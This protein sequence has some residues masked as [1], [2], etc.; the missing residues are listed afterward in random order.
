MAAVE[1]DPTLAER[2]VEQALADCAA[3]K[4]GGSVP[5]ARQALREGRCEVCGALG[6]SLA[7]Q[8]SEFVGRMDPTVKALYRA[9]GEP[10]ARLL[11]ANGGSR[12]GLNLVAWVERKSAALH[13][14]AGALEAGLAERRRQLGCRN[15][16]PACFT[17]DL[18]MVD[19]DDVQAGRGPGLMVQ[20]GRV[21][22][23]PIWQ[24]AGPAADAPEEAPPLTAADPDLVPE[25]ALFAQAQAIERLPARDR[26]RLA[27]GARDLKVALIRRLISDQLPYI[28]VAKEWLTLEDLAGIYAHKIGQGRIGGKAAGMLLAARILTEAGDPAVRAALRVPESYFLGSDL[29]Y[30][31]MAMNGLMHW[32]EQKYKPEA[33]IRAEYAQI[34][35]E[36][37]A[38]RFPPEIVQALAAMLARVGPRPLI[39]RS[40]SQLE[41]N[42][43]TSFAGKYDSVFCPNQGTP[44]AN[45]AALTTA[46]AR[47]Y[48]STLKPEALLYRRGKG[49]QDYDER[50]AVL[51]QAVQG[52][53]FGRYYLPFA[54]GVAFSRNLYRW[55]PALRPEAGFVRLV[56]GLGTRAVERVGNDYP[57]LI[58]LSH[59]TLQ[60][61]DTPEALR[62][63]SQHGVD[64][65]DLEAN[66]PCCLPAAEVLTPRYPWLRYLA[67][68]DDDGFLT[69]PRGTLTA[70]D[71]PR[72]VLT[73]DGLVR[74]TPAAALLS[75]MLR[76]LEERYHTAVDLEFTLA[77]QETPGAP[78]QVAISLLQCRPQSML[79]RPAA[80]AL[81]R[82]PAPE[83]VV[84]GTRFM[85]PQGYLN[86]L[87]YVVFVPPEG[88]FALQAPACRT[89]LTQAIAQLNA[90]L[91]E[92]T[93]ILVGPGRWG[94]TN[95]G[96]G[97]YVSYADIHNAAALV[98]L[99]GRGVG[100]APEPSLGTH[101]FQ[102]LMEAQIYPLAVSLDD[103]A[104]RFNRAFFYETPNRLAD[105]LPAGQGLADCL[106]LIEVADFRGGH[107]LEVIMDDL[108][109]Q[110]LALLVPDA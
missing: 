32:N 34:Q 50:M 16:R 36:F 88:Y 27:A 51:I 59:P 28:N 71:V 12:G 70:A 68:L 49:L 109:G 53:R 13:M 47:I 24:R 73:F 101:F 38:G 26:E 43:G 107:H 20:R 15:A 103:P 72:L 52:E 78:P 74:R 14:L 57:H 91:G 95:P 63:Y 90:A 104:S 100:P 86:H 58:A 85:V 94:T 6:D 30:L 76:T 55:S 40:S 19:D 61:D 102:D 1:L 37:Q 67:Q 93:F 80:A 46:I 92:K 99:S 9:E 31:F 11:D 3:V 65:L 108:Q 84:F 21:R 60:P 48:A 17:L 81:P 25:S 89:A 83:S 2:L 29:I 69:A 5:Q 4:L 64:V 98:E 56:W 41:D 10:G 110:A 8:V 79:R 42:F 77:L 18:Q 66:A 35:A 39:V 97:V 105:R 45:L 62:F 96:L 87:R 22:A 23:Q 75:R 7:R 106:R 33:Q 44:A 54:A 82:H